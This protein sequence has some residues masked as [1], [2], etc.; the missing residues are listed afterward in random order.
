MINY[1]PE[2]AQADLNQLFEDLYNEMN[3]DPNIREIL[4]KYSQSITKILNNLKI[5]SGP[6]ALSG[7]SFNR[8]IAI[9]DTKSITL[10]ELLQQ[11]NLEKLHTWLVKN[12]EIFHFIYSAPILA[13]GKNPQYFTQEGEILFDEHN[14]QFTITRKLAGR[15]QAGLANFYTNGQKEILIK[16]E[17]DKKTKHP[18]P[19][20]CLLEGTGTFVK[21][22][23]YYLKI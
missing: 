8:P 19:G 22:A 4:K 6:Q 14:N 18:D 15:G 1:G 10:W 5:Q 17:I 16:E 13:I 7:L 12:Q 9:S 3:A 2:A 23:G 11:F 21:D 20:T